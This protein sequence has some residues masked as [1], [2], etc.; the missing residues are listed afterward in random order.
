MFL[1]DRQTEQTVEVT[2]LNMECPQCLRISHTWGRWQE[3]TARLEGVKDWAI[4]T[5]SR[6][7]VTSLPNAF[8]LLQVEEQYI[9]F[10]PFYIPQ[11]DC[12]ERATE[13]GKQAEIFRRASSCIVW[14][15]DIKEWRS[16][17][18]AMAWLSANYLLNTSPDLGGISMLGTK[19]EFMLATFD[20]EI[21]DSIFGNEPTARAKEELQQYVNVRPEKGQVTQTPGA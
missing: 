15:N 8:R 11:N 16:L 2:L 21:D 3:S 5:N 4:P 10:H 17:Q 19:T 14:M 1:W 13:I 20:G 7:D 6:F 12:P 9:W 18:L